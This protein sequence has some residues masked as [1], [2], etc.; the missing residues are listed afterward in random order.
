MDKETRAIYELVEKGL[1][2]K[3]LNDEETEKLYAVDP[4]SPEGFYLMWAGR[5][6]QW[7]SSDGTAEV[8]AQIGLNS[9]PCPKNCLFCSFAVCNGVRKGKVE[10]PKEDVVEYSKI[11]EEQ[12]ANAILLM[13]TATYKFDQLLEMLAAV[14]EVISPNMPLLANT[15]DVTAEQAKR[16]KA[17]GANG[18]YHAVRMREGVDTAIPVATRLETFAN[19]KAAGLSLST[20]VEPVGPEHSARELAEATRI[21][22]DSGALSAG[23]GRRIG[24]PGTGVYE[25]GMHST[26]TI[27]MYVAVYRLATGLFPRLN[28][29][30][31]TDLIAAAGANLAWAEVGTN[32]R[33][34]QKRT[35]QG[36]RG[37]NIDFARK[38]F[39]D[40]GYRVVEGPS[41]GW[42]LD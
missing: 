32:P 6:L 16:L 28:C 30:G 7:Q 38:V 19:L 13:T 1:E 36:G 8:H 24:V 25:R 4:E 5:K 39:T 2:G 9:S 23:V 22:I 12:G 35:E 17:A 42:I 33:D 37:V 3:G 34:T 27:G 10:L 20:C 11:Y 41:E 40:A 31:G 29:A 15:G 21:C 14:R 26:L 18:C